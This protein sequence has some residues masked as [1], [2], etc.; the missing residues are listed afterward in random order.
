MDQTF[1]RLADNAIFKSRYKR[2]YL[3]NTSKAGRERICIGGGAEKVILFLFTGKSVKEAC[4]S[5]GLN[6]EELQSFLDTLT[7]ERVIAWSN[8][9]TDSTM[10]CHDIEPPLD[11]LN[12]LLTNVCNLRC[13][14]CYVSSGKRMSGE[15]SGE[16]WIRVLQEARELGVFE[17]NISGGEATLHPDFTKIVEYIASVPTFHANLN[18]N[19]V[20]LQQKHE[21]AIA[22]AFTSVQVSIDDA[23]ASKHD[24][25]RGRKGSFSLSL[26]TIKRLI[27]RG[28]STSI[29]FT[30]THNS[31]A[32]IDNVVSLAEDLGVDTLNI[33]LIASIGRAADNHLV[34]KFCSHKQTDLFMDCLYQKMKKL[35]ARSSHVRILLPFRIPEDDFTE[36]VSDKRFICDGENT[37]ILYIMANGTV[38]PCDKL[39][40]ETFAYGNVRNGSLLAT[41]QS[42]QMRNF[43]L[44]SPSTLPRCGKCSHLKICGGACVARAHQDGGSLESPDWTSCSIAQRLSQDMEKCT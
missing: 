42:K 26:S 21:E 9:S 23:T 20:M 13:S 4:N 35:A 15:L 18:T 24:T 8:I 36:E 3:I 41:W 30:I 44:R 2:W 27:A 29:G 25:F 43:K 40:M 11:G 33:G 39:P 37:Q 1:I 7:Q 28:V 12:L 16:E 34:N 38:M 31:L 32:A 6:T 5:F 17:V 10:R 22:S 14:H 19:G